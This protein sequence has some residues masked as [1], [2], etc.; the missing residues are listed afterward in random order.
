MTHQETPPLA[1][2]HSRQQALQ[3]SFGSESGGVAAVFSGKAADYQA[4]RPGYPL[5]LLQHLRQGLPAAA[6]VVDLGAGTGLLSAGLLQQGLRVTAVEPSAAMRSA[7]EQALG[8]EPGFA[9]SAGSAEA[10][11]L[12]QGCADLITAAQAFHW[13]DI[14]A[15]RREC[16]RLL[17]P[18]AQVA[19]IWNDRV[20][21][22]PLQQ[23][24]DALFDAF[25]G[26]RRAAQKQHMSPGD[27]GERAGL[28]QFFGGAVPA[29]LHWPHEHWL[30]EA[31]LASL[32]FS[33]S[34][35]PARASEEGQVLLGHL[36]RLFARFASGPRLAMRYRTLAV[37][38]RPAE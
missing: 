15:A 32:A 14:E 18:G 23:E 24:L 16:L 10:T 31:G 33:R 37:I 13:F 38:G 9:S 2:A 20:R 3:N 28:P 6:H 36:K 27:E 1:A 35:I 22:D 34:Y 29:G 8:R 17:K 7:A 5:G 4:A 12:T 30:D 11:G 26:A 19:L 25:G 21:E